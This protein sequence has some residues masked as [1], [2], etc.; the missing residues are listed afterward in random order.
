MPC[1]GLC[2]REP[3]ARRQ[4]GGKSVYGLGYKGCNEC[5]VWMMYEG[6][7]CPCCG[8]TLRRTTRRKRAEVTARFRRAA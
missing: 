5:R 2:V 6:W 1:R 3:T 7:R 8:Q 4:G